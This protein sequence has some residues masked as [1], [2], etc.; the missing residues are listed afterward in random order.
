MF[1][2]FY[3]SSVLRNILIFTLLMPIIVN[4]SVTLIYRLPNMQREK[5]LNYIV[6]SGSNEVL[7]NPMFED[8]RA[9]R[10]IL[11]EAGEVQYISDD[12]AI[13]ENERYIDYLKRQFV[14]KTTK[15][16]LGNVL[17]ED[18]RFDHIAMGEHYYSVKRI[19]TDSTSEYD[20]YVLYNSE[21]S[22]YFFYAIRQIYAIN[23][24]CMVG[25]C[26]LSLLLAFWEVRPAK[27]AWKEQK[28]F[29][30]NASHE[31]KTPV[32]VA[33]TS[34]ELLKDTITEEQR[35]IFDIMNNVTKRIMNI[36][37]DLMF[38]S[39]ADAKRI[40]L[41]VT[42]INLQVLLLETYI[43]M[44]VIAMAKGVKF[45]DLQ[46]EDISMRGDD[47][48]L[49]QLFSILLK[50]AIENTPEG[51]TI[52]LSAKKTGREIEIM[53]NDTGIG[54]SQKDQKHIFQRFYRADYSRGSKNG[55]FGLGL[56]IAQW[57]M[58]QH[59]GKIT[60]DSTVGKGSTFKVTF[61]M[62]KLPHETKE[63]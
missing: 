46:C 32:T 53:V 30:A 3:I 61:F 11:N 43:P 19:E 35:D 54:I 63:K 16:F 38:I 42:N 1:K 44:E 5:M 33:T 36:V 25:V 59:R 31:L 56:S 8:Y 15:S 34:L 12:K 6:E 27:R 57:I 18:D 20:L 26:I 17:P 62:Y 22:G 41:E 13:S 28:D 7:Q 60:V 37:N 4:Y 48:K 50:N 24:I 2:R 29:F 45:A 10:V 55:N 49:R 51:G 14:L 23:R 21:N 9:F 40:K 58:K 39:R 52:S 47:E